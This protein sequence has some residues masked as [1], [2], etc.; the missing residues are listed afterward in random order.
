[1]AA[2]PDRLARFKRQ[3]QVLVSLNHSNVA[4]ILRLRESAGV[5]ALILELVDGPT[6]A[7]RIAQGPSRWTRRCRSPLRSLKPSKRRTRAG[8]SI[9]ISSRQA[10]NSARMAR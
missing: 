3:A 9:A 10:S 1:V 4:A 7:E 8:S 2:D 6:L 5:Q